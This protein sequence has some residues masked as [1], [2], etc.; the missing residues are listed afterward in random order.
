[1]IQ[2]GRPVYAHQSGGQYLYFHR[3]GSTNKWDG[4]FQEE[5]GP[6]IDPKPKLY[7]DR[8][9]WIFAAELGNLPESPGC[10]GF[11]EDNAVTPDQISGTWKVKVADQMQR[12]PALK[13]V[14]R[15]WSD[16]HLLHDTG[17]SGAAR[18]MVRS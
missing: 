10:H 3:K 16:E 1:M 6:G 17:T 8:G 2:F 4:A 9:Y 18:T 5:L 11:V 12:S 14:P 7:E 13:L 15:E